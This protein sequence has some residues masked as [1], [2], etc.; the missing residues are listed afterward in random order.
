MD[1]KKVNRLKKHMEEVET[2]KARGA[3][4]RSRMK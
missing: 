2:M 3:A 4:I 1:K